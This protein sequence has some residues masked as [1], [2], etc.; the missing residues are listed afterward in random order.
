MN[1]CYDGTVAM[2]DLHNG[3]FVTCMQ[4]CMS[5]ENLYGRCLKHSRVAHTAQSDPLS[6]L[7]L[8]GHFIGDLQAVISK[9]VA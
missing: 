6:Q 2:S 9:P 7:D 8:I 1:A 4:V 3:S 5:T